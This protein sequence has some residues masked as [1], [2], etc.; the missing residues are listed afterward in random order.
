MLKE[1]LNKQAIFKLI[2]VEGGENN[3]PDYTYYL[4]ENTI[5]QFE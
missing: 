1:S 3:E 2:I 5:Q 4:I